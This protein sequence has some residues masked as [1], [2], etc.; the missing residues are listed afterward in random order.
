MKCFLFFG[1]QKGN[2]NEKKTITSAEELQ[3]TATLYLKDC[4]DF[5]LVVDSPCTKVLIG[6]FI[7]INVYFPLPSLLACNLRILVNLHPSFLF[8]HFNFSFR[9]LYQYKGRPESANQDRDS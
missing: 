2:K 5:E 8:N 3:A 6:T 9:G 7:L 1:I 4:H